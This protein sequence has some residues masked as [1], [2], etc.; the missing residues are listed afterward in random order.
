[1]IPY[2]E[3]LPSGGQNFRKKI[4]RLKGKLFQNGK[5]AI[6]T[7]VLSMFLDRISK[8]EKLLLS[9]MNEFRFKNLMIW[10]TNS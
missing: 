4:G 1:M 7:M 6:S 8:A 10:K 5:E 9:E 3:K 2:K